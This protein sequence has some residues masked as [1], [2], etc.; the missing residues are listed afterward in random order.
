VIFMSLTPVC[1]E[2]YSIQTHVIFMSDSCPWWDVLDTNSCNIKWVWLL[3][4]MR[5]TWYKLMWYYEFDSCQRLNV[6][7]ANSCDIYEFISCP[8]RNVLDSILYD[9]IF[10]QLTEE[11]WCSLHS[12]VPPKKG[13]IMATTIVW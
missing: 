1:G 2:I 11:W 12:P 3:P 6:R 4:M 9:R 7:D 13:I 5:C 10:P 8:W